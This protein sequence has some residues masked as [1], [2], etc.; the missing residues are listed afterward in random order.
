M[1]ESKNSR[2]LNAFKYQKQKQLHIYVYI[3]M[4]I[5]YIVIY[6][7]HDNHKPKICNR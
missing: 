5:F 4:H 1:G 3:Y 2:S 7:P 6:K